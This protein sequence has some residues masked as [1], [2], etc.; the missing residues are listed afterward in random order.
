MDDPCAA[1]TVLISE[2]GENNDAPPA[3]IDN[4]NTRALLRGADN[5]SLE[6]VEDDESMTTTTLT[7]SVTMEYL[8][9]LKY[10]DL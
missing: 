4:G 9:N 7:P 6:E 2:I 1:D 3:P 8:K 10:N 5:N